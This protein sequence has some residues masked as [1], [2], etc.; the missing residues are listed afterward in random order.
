MFE[1]PQ[2]WAW[3]LVILGGYLL[4]NA[5]FNLAKTLVR[6][7]GAI[8]A[9]RISFASALLSNSWL[10]A[11]T[12]VV[13]IAFGRELRVGMPALYPDLFLIFIGLLVLFVVMLIDFYLRMVVR[14]RLGLQIILEA[15]EG[16]FFYPGSVAAWELAL[17]NFSILKPFAY[18]LFLRGMVLAT[19]IE[20]TSSLNIAAS[21]ILSVAVIAFIEFIL[22]PNP[23]RAV[24]TVI[25]SFTLSMIYLASAGGVVSSIIT[26][27]S[28]SILLSLY[29]M[30]LVLRAMSE[31][32]KEPDNGQK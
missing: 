11:S 30:H 12:L 6:R 16:L 5:G 24:A 21:Y 20:L 7:G 2:L 31:E 29:L 8:R 10:V 27:V 14:R 4:L 22:Q 32:R 15:E 28:A 13:S 1:N 17:F 19:V 26:R 3:P 23:E 9:L 25:T 18:E